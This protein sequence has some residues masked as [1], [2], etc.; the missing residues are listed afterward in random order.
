VVTANS[1]RRAAG[2]ASN[3]P[4]FKE[5]AISQPLFFLKKHYI[6]FYKNLPKALIMDTS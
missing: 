2:W 1:I 3:G 6:E 4:I 5:L